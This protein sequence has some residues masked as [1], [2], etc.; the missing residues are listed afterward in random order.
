ME[1]VVCEHP[2]LGDL[3]LR[4]VFFFSD[5]VGELRLP[6]ISVRVDPECVMALIQWISL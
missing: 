5:F 4:A 2:G 3:G 1:P 6:F